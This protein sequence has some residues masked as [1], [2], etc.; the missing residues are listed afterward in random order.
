L[1]LSQLLL[2]LLHM[3]A[4]GAGLSYP[5]F[6]F[7]IGRNERWHKGRFAVLF[8]C[9]VDHLA[10]GDAAYLAGYQILGCDLH[11]NLH[12]STA[13]IV[14]R[15]IHG[16]YI[17]D[18]GR[19]QEIETF[20]TNDY[21]RQVRLQRLK[22]CNL[23]SPPYVLSSKNMVLSNVVMKAYW[24]RL[25]CEWHNRVAFCATNTLLE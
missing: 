22:N 2:D 24:K 3:L 7:G 14:Q 19:C 1:Q 17:A 16:N 20:Y 10:A 21:D 23:S 11:T 4:A 12:A 13:N 5:R 9:H 18:V 15:A 6:L 25:C 8:E